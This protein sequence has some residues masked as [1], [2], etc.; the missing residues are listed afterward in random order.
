MSKIRLGALTIA[1]LLALGLPTQADEKQDKPEPADDRK[2]RA[3][4]PDKTYTNEDLERLFPRSEPEP[5]P[6]AEKGADDGAARKA[7]QPDAAEADKGTESTQA[8][9]DSAGNSLQWLDERKAAQRE[10][11]KALAEAGAAV[12]DAEARVRE[13]EER[14]RALRNP[15]LKR[16]AAPE[17]DPEWAGRSTPERVAQTEAELEGARAEMTRAQ[18]ELDRLRAAGP[19]PSA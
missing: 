18:S 4:E 6:D 19:A 12:T 3:T 9:Q 15:L 7:G 1:A 17:D 2:D 5:S 14:L 11:Q 8:K 10:H 13:L 16:P